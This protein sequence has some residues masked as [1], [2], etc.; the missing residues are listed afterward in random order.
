VQK[1]FIKNDLA[2]VF[3]RT[4]RLEQKHLEEGIKLSE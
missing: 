4:L 1:I 2:S 3:D